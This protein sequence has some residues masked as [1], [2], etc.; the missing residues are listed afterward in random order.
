MKSVFLLSFIFLMTLTLPGFSNDPPQEKLQ[1][2]SQ[3]GVS[4]QDNTKHYTD[5]QYYLLSSFNF[6]AYRNYATKRVVRIE[7]GPV[8][9]L[10]SLQEMLQNGKSIS[11][12][13]L[14]KKSNEVNDANLKRV[15]T[16]INIGFRYG[17]IKHT[18]TGF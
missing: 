17:P 10:S 5:H 7:D 11:D 2:L 12:D 3:N 6:D 14:Q 4:L 9:E 8:I 1:Q 18:E 16:L 13:L 15:I